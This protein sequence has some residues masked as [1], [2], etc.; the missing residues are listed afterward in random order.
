MNNFL[1]KQS[2]TMAIAIFMFPVSLLANWD[3]NKI[4]QADEGYIP[5]YDCQSLDAIRNNLEGKYQLT[6]SFSCE[7]YDFKP[8]GSP[9]LFTGELNGLFNGE[10][11][12]I[13]DLK[14]KDGKSRQL[15]LFSYTFNAV[16]ENVI[17]DNAEIVGVAESIGALVGE[18]GGSTKIFNNELK[19]SVVKVNVHD[20]NGAIGGLVGRAKGYR[21]FKALID[22]NT[23]SNTTVDGRNKKGFTVGGMVGFINEYTNVTN[24]FGIGNRV[25]GNTLVGGVIGG[26][27]GFMSSNPDGGIENI[28]LRDSEIIG[29]YRI[30]GLVGSVSG[31][32][33]E[34]ASISNTLI[35]NENL[36][37]FSFTGGIVGGFYNGRVKKASVD[38]SVTIIGDT[39][40]GGLVGF[41]RYG[42]DIENSYSHASVTGNNI[43]GGLVG[44]IFGGS[45]DKIIHSYAAGKVTV[46]AGDKAGGLVG[47]YEDL[48]P[49]TTILS[50]WDWQTTGQRTSAGGGEPKSTVEMMRKVTYM[51]I[52]YPW[53]FTNIW[54]I[55][56]NKSYPY[57][58]N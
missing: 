52:R 23:V 31:R 12:T 24:T 49:G 33:I 16:I 55:D 57:L 10:R 48:E 42:V 58:R 41:Y 28:H 11:Q 47:N 32:T 38:D 13:S 19:N 25:L 22:G 21:H 43:V 9:G 5:V 15:G 34:N 50:F 20:G 37:S 6:A 54:N 29:E 46:L 53:D 51:N 56:E 45:D 1:V 36:G 40:V 4:S 7:G 30:G 44:K 3:A 8:I 35:K 2:I 18:A 14:I 17:L 26:A 39:Y 27:S